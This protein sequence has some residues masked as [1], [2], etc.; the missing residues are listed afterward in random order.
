MPSYAK[1]A[2]GSFTGFPVRWPWGSLAATAWTLRAL[3]RREQALTGA[4][5]LDLSVA[6]MEHWGVEIAYARPFGLH[7][8][9]AA[10]HLASD[11]LH[12]LRARLAHTGWRVAQRL[13]HQGLDA[14]LE[15]PD[16]QAA[17]Q[18]LELDTAA[19]R[20]QLQ[21]IESVWRV[22]LALIASPA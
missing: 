12:G 15:D 1:T 16:C 11:A 21:Q 6:L 3:L 4:N 2:S 22:W 5:H 19:L 13:S 20:E 18:W 17:L 14:V 7:E 8:V 10:E 9:P